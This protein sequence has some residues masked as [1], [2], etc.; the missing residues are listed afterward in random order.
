VLGEALGGAERCR[1]P[2]IA[3][4]HRGLG[5]TGTQ[6]ERAAGHLDAAPDEL[7]VPRRLTDHIVGIVAGLRQAVVTT[8]ATDNAA[9]R[10]R[11]SCRV[12]WYA[13]SSW[14]PVRRSGPAALGT[15]REWERP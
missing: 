5:I 2:G 9:E 13:V 12:R 15:H 4:A 10:G 3:G 7:G 1:Q 8:C 14:Y 11:R 6:F